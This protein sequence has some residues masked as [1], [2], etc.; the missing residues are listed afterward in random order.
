LFHGNELVKVDESKRCVCLDMIMDVER[1]FVDDEGVTR[2]ECSWL[3]VEA[4]KLFDEAMDLYCSP[5]SPQR[6]ERARALMEKGEH[7]P[8][9]RKTFDARALRSLGPFQNPF[10]K[11]C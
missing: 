2:V 7:L 10:Q 9:L 6:R 11:L 5:T 4:A 8:R 1:V 3:S